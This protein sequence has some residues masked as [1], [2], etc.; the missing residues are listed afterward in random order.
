VLVEVV[1]IMVVVVVMVVVQLLYILRVGVEQDSLIPFKLLSL[2][3]RMLLAILAY[4]VVVEVV[5]EQIIML[6]L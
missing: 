4:L 3:S 2:W 5:V 6:L 1:E